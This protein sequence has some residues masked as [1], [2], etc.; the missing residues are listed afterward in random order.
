[1][2]PPNICTSGAY[3]LKQEIRSGNENLKRL[4]ILSMHRLLRQERTNKGVINVTFKS[5]FVVYVLRK[6]RDHLCG[7]VV[8][9][10]GYR[11]EMYCASCEVRTEFLYVM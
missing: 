11:T 6:I 2:Q 3:I 10:R 9:V 7:L 5:S 1:M 4:Q 8:R